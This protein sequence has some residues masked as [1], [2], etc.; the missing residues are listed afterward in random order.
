MKEQHYTAA[1]NLVSRFYLALD[2]NDGEVVVSLFA[3]GGAWHRGAE[4]FQGFKSI[5]ELLEKRD[6]TRVTCHQ[7]SNLAV[8]AQA[9]CLHI[10]YYLT[11][12]VDQESQL[13]PTTVLLMKEILIFEDENWLIQSKR[14]QPHLR[15]NPNGK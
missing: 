14:S 6:P 15:F 8:Q 3:K 13:I 12:Y 1:A 5:R 4:V 10:S 7:I 11:V 2:N 9:D